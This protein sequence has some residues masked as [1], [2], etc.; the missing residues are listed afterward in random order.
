[1]RLLRQFQVREIQMLPGAERLYNASEW[2]DGLVIVERGAL[3]LETLGGVRRRFCPGNALFLCG[4]SLRLLRN[5]G[6]EIAVL[7]AVSRRLRSNS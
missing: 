5:P 6:G 1:M 3:E 7:F 2:R 4:L